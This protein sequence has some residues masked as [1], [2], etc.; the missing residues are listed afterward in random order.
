MGPWTGEG[1]WADR[2]RER[3][4]STMLLRTE[5]EAPKEVKS[6]SMAWRTETSMGRTRS[7]ADREAAQVRTVSQLRHALRRVARA[8]PSGVIVVE[9]AW[10][11]ASI[12]QGVE[13]AMVDTMGSQL[14]SAPSRGEPSESFRSA[15]DHAGHKRGRAAESISWMLRAVGIA[16]AVQRGGMVE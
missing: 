1:R 16:E 4:E 8:V 6:Q 5:L 9:K 15:T 14:P 12:V 10:L 2:C 3:T 7:R 13:E 11:I